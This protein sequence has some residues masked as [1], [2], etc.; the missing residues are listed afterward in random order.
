MIMPL[1]LSVEGD[2]WNTVRADNTSHIPQARLVA[3]PKTRSASSMGITVS[4]ESK[5]E[6]AGCE[7]NS[8]SA[9]Y[10]PHAE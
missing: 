9:R 1:L 2:L 10:T 3:A 6:G 4:S 5:L 8:C 7:T